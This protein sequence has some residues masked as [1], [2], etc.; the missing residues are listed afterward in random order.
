MQVRSKCEIYQLVTHFYDCLFQG[1][2]YIHPVIIT[3]IGVIIY[4]FFD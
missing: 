4:L 3:I 2:E 1:F